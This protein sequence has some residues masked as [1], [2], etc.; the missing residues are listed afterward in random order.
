MSLYDS[1]LD[2]LVRTHEEEGLIT[3]IE[4]YTKLIKKYK[5]L[6]REEVEVKYLNYLINQFEGFRKITK[7]ALKIKQSEVKN[8]NRNI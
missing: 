1:T 4:G 3:L 8:E 7:D 2:Y 6:R 5:E